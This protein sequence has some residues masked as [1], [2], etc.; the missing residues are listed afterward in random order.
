MRLVGIIIAVIG[1][2]GA[3]INY[4]DIVHLTGVLGNVRNWGVVV[5]IGVAIFFF[6][7]RPSD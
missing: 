4:Y 2:L 3:A 5:A 7:R 1:I 6:F